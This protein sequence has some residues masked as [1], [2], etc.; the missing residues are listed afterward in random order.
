MSFVVAQSC[1]A[2]CGCVWCWFDQLFESV[3]IVFEVTAAQLVVSQEFDDLLLQ[4]ANEF[5][6]E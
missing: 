6:Q 4:L 3:M 5:C 1:L 2:E